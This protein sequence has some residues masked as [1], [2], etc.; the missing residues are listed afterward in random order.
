MVSADGV[1]CWLNPYGDTQFLSF[2]DDAKDLDI[3]LQY[4]LFLY[5]YYR[6]INNNLWSF[7]LT[8]SYYYYSLLNAPGT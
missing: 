7:L 1:S 5:F 6:I 4:Y 3:K 2:S 8:E